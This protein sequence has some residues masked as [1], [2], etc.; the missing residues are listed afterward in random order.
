MGVEKEEQAFSVLGTELKIT[1]FNIFD[2][3]APAKDT[4]HCTAD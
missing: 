2:T 3:E 1:E 4:N